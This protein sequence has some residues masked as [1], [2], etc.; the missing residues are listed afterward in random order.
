MT[1]ASFRTTEKEEGGTAS[2]PLKELPPHLKDAIPECHIPRGGRER[3]GARR[4]LEGE[5]L[6]DGAG[7]GLV[8]DSVID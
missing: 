3:G 5:S 2:R 4:G 8:E 6:Y 1:F 7:N